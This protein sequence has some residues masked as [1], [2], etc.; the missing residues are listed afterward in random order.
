VAPAELEALLMQHPAITD[1][2]VVGRPHP[3]HGEEPIAYVVAHPDL[4]LAAV[5]AWL[6][7]RVAPYKQPAQLIVV[8]QLP[9]TPSGKLLR[10][11]LSSA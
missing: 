11:H 1:A 4:D 7:A 5:H 10:R 8:D 9:R 6:A 3:R 2:G